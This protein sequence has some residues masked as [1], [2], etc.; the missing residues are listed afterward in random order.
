MMT[1][2]L[3]LLLGTAYACLGLS[4]LRMARLDGQGR[5]WGRLCAAGV[6]SALL[7]WY[8]LYDAA[9]GTRQ[10]NDLAGSILALAALLAWL[11]FLRRATLGRFKLAVWQQVA[12]GLAAAGLAAGA[13][14]FYEA[15]SADAFYRGIY[16]R[17]LFAQRS[18]GLLA[19]GIALVAVL[20]LPGPGE[21][22]TRL[23]GLALLGGLLGFLVLY[24]A[25]VAPSALV[26]PLVPGAAGASA[27]LRAVYVARHRAG[28]GMFGRWALLE[29]GVLALL[30]AAA[31]LSARHRGQE[32]MLLEQRQLLR[33]T[34]AAA[35]A[36]DPANV[37]QLA[38]TPADTDPAA[39]QAV[40]R[41]LLT[42]QKITRATTGAGHG[43]RF[44][45][46]LA[47]RGGRVVFLADQPEDPEQPTHPGEPYDEASPELRR[48]L[49]DGKP[50][51]EGP[52]PDRYGV[53]VSAFAP[54][55][56]AQG[57][58][59]ALLGIDFDAADWDLIEREARLSSL[60]NWTL[61]MMI[62]LS[63]FTSVG[64]GLE[65]Q[66]QLRRSEQLFRT[67]ADYTS[68][69]DYWVGPD[70]R[71]IYTSLASEKITG[72]PPARF[73]RHPRRLLKIV[74]PGD[75]ARVSEHLRA[76]AH[77]APACE[78]DFKIVRKNGEA[79]W[80]KHSCESVY[81]DDGI[82][83]GRRASN[84]D[85]TALRTAELALARQERLQGGCH[86]ALRRLLGRDGAQYIQEA[87]DLAAPAGGCCRAAV[88]RIGADD[89]VRPIAAW[90]PGTEIPRTPVWE[91]WRERA[92]PVLAVGE[93]F[94]LLPR[95]TRTFPG[96]LSGA[97]IA[98]LPILERGQLTG[99]AAFAAPAEH[100]LWSRAE[101]AALATLASG[102]SV[103]L[104]Q[105]GQA[106]RGEK[107]KNFSGLV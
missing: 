91:A 41:R 38:A 48:A 51:V 98:I 83:S 57:K 60:L 58:V 3:P 20:P 102:F 72:Y 18:V 4:G 74:D 12:A 82:W 2:F 44:A 62:A 50:F 104:G 28:T 61:I 17:L 84:R 68:T 22:R 92:L 86:Q 55:L 96:G 31:F 105:R 103:A 107:S 16:Q 70:G 94:E 76:C 23:A 63:L 19:G 37:G 106:E 46:L 81:D 6:A 39:F 49:V 26:L 69:W 93:S 11:E 43:S 66:H 10:P 95:E 42:I 100:G 47:L 9:V 75:R 5:G 53:W 25:G 15:S 97:H 33:T 36:F 65:A 80:I 54:I 27:L 64:L 1:D 52:L 59:L 78:F 34:Q 7:A 67:A 77:D 88:F 35:A 14:A 99:V 29:F 40:S 89:H 21:R 73:A 56:D 13:F 45:Y 85:I 90:P 87:L 8:P 101:I 24:V 32:T 79:A 30:L 71:M